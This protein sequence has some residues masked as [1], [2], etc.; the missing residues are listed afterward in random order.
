MTAYPAPSLPYMEPELLSLNRGLW[1]D[2]G[3][4]QELVLVSTVFRQALGPIQTLGFF[5]GNKAAGE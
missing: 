4:M 5:C 1:F 3:R 2:F